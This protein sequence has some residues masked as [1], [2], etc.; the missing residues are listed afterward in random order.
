M[1]K[2]TSISNYISIFEKRIAEQVSRIKN[3][4]NKPKN[5]RN[6]KLL[7]H[8][9]HDVKKI[10]QAVKQAKTDHVQLCPHCNKAI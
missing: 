5:A 3:E 2:T 8:L 9:L 7:K 4:L 10:K 6:K 1:E